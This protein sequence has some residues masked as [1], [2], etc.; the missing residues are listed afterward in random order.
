MGDRQGNARTRWGV[1]GKFK[2]EDVDEWIR[3]RG[4]AGSSDELADEESNKNG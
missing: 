3:A 1:S 4:A 2:R